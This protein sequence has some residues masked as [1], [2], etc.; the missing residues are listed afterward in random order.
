VEAQPVEAQAVEEPT[1]V[2]PDL[3][4][5]LPVTSYSADDLDALAAWIVA[6]DGQTDPEH[7]TARLREEL[8]LTRRGARADAIL[9]AV[10]ARLPG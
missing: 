8:G 1:P 5:G 7:V 2:R 3:E 10:V 4:R 9:D 6:T